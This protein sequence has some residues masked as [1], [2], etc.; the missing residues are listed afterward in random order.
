[1]KDAIVNKVASSGLIEINLG[2]FYDKKPRKPI[3]LSEFLFQG[4]ILKEKDY[5]AALES[6][7]TENFRDAHV[8]VFCSADAIVPV[9]AYMLM[10]SKLS[11]ISASVFPG[12]PE[13]MERHL[14]REAINRLD[15]E[16]YRDK[17]I[18][19][20][21]CGDIPIPDSAFLD[22]THRLKQVAASI[23]YGEPCSTVPVFK[24]PAQNKPSG[25]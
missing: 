10:A 5:R 1:M 8:A 9:W 11:G 24:K 13:E 16:I 20:K 22:I 2:E 19:V 15:P 17:K 14:F 3:D 7:D 21:G 12:S 4:L 6:L 23:M 18:I 25:K